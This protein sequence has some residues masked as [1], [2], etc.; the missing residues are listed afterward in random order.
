MWANFHTHCDYCDGKGPMQDY[1]DKAKQLEMLSLGFSSHA[2][3]PFDTKWCM[4]A[5]R[6]DEYSETISAL[7]KANTGLDIYA[8]LEVDF[9][10]NV[11]SP[12]SF[13][14]AVDYTIGSV[15]FVDKHPDGRWWE[16][17][18]L[19]AS[20]IDGLKAIFNNNIQAA[21]VRY[22]ELTREMIITACPTV[23]GHLD[24][25]KIQNVD[26]KFFSESESWYQHEIKKT[27]DL[28]ST[29][30]SIVEV[31]TRGIYQRKSDTTYPSPWILSYLHKKNVPIT[32]SS[33]AH[34]P[35]DLILQFSETAMMLQNIGFKTL[36]V[37]SEGR[38]KPLSF[39]EHGIT[40]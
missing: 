38:W 36:S 19:H 23:V 25:I 10:P 2:P 17:D 13:K 5:E 7:K 37:L 21:I 3:V 30:G 35:K 33:D 26:G 39:D 12:D 28:I 40:R 32:I 18:G 31:N 11:T 27:V 20:F 6:L 29:T 16:I 34:H 8:G 1:V 9:I 15:H 22:F 14:K 24:K 4:K